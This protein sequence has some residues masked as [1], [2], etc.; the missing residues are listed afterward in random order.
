V[1]GTPTPRR[2]LSET[3]VGRT[4][5]LDR[6]ESLLDASG[7]DGRAVAIT[8][9]AGLGKTRLAKSLASEARARGRLVLVGRASPLE[10][11]LPL[12]VMQDALREERRDPGDIPLPTDSLAAAFPA[13]LLPELTAPGDA[14]RTLD[15]GA[16]L[17]A[18]ARYLRARASPGG[19]VLVLEDLHWADPTTH[20][21][22]GYL[23]RAIQ[24]APILLVLTY[25]SDEAPPGSS[26]SGLRHELARERLGEELGLEP[27][28]TDDVALM[29]AEILGT[30]VGRDVASMVVR[31]SGGNPFIV[32]ELVRDAVALGAL[33]PDRGVWDLS[34][35]IALPGTVQEMLLRRMRALD[36]AD[37]ELVRWAAVLGERFDADV[38]AVAAGLREQAALDTLGR[39]REVGLVA[40]ARDA[41][42]GRL[43]FRHALT[44]Q[45]VLAGMIA[46]ER[47]RRHA[48]VLE[49]VAGGDGPPKAPLDEV[50]EH[51]LGAGDRARGF[52]CSIEAAGRAVAL[53]GYSEARSHLERALALWAPEDGLPIR[54]DLLMRLGYLMSHLGGGFL[55][56]MQQRQSRQYFEEAGA[57]YEQI[58][59]DDSAAL[60]TAGSVWS[61]R[62]VDVVDDLR[63]VLARL[64][65]TSS[66]DAICQIL[67][68]LGDREFLLGRTRE[69]L[70]TCAEGLSLLEASGEGRDPAQFP[71]RVQLRRSL[72]LTRAAAT[73]WLGDA[74]LG[75]NAML[76]LVDDALA[77]NDHLLAA[78]AL[79]YL[80]RQSID[81]PLE[82]AVFARRGSE[83]AGRHGLSST[84][85]WLGHLDAQAHVH[86][87]RWD[88]AEALLDHAEAV[89]V[90][91]PDQPF[92]RDTLRMVRSELALGRGDLDDVVT[93]LTPLAREIDTRHGRIFR[94]TVR[95]ALARAS[96][97]RDEP[98]EATA[99]LAPVLELWDRDEEGPFLLSA[100]LP[101]AS[102]EAASANGDATGAA[103]WS[104]ELASLRCGP[105]AD[106]ARALAAL[107]RGAPG[108]A[109]VVEAAAR[110]I[111]SDGRRWEG[112]WMRYAGARV[113]RDAGDGD[114]AASLAGAAL[115]RFREMGSDGWCRMGEALLRGLGHRVP[116]RR[117]PQGP[118]GLTLRELEVLRLIVD[119]CTNRA[120]AARLVIS[121]GTAGRHVSNV[122]AKLGAHS[123]LDAARIASERR[124]LERP[125]AV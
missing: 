40:D 45:A 120:I 9:E 33:D 82:A 27:L 28:E 90:E 1:T 109:P 7:I 102:A 115:E 114:G 11:A 44:R 94:R 117:T 54:A 116:G 74:A 38:L 93:S 51:A 20:A 85:A 63:A 123:R 56:W 68:R 41:T 50:L 42:D 4:A 71:R 6:L 76:A 98:A 118:G 88:E 70:R 87:G 96:M 91:V 113:A 32:E 78:L 43:A 8:G 77:E 92:V 37:R 122:Y 103:R 67:C 79:N 62:V 15:R 26:L 86:L 124:L 125:A 16:L 89:L 29:L 10:A 72:H 60:A 17:E 13:L 3:I 48:R 19:L 84:V 106:Y 69:A 83:L 101:M 53:G 39:L 25:R 35:P 59:D 105:R 22:V 64:R 52:A 65:S 111:D 49:I 81:R 46:P 95:V 2:F 5:I 58:G 107:A 14:G 61:R 104:D 36:E 99:V 24:D 119:G 12:A 110:R 30:D 57:L 34:E 23:A 55:L 75:R 31:A 66:P 18:A 21:L 73:W 97:A 112:A 108:Q 100:L 47:R 80:T 121:E